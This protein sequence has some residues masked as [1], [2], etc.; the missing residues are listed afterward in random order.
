[1]RFTKWAENTWITDSYGRKKNISILNRSFEEI[2]MYIRKL[3]NA[4]MQ[5]LATFI[6]VDSNTTRNEFLI[7]ENSKDSQEVETYE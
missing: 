3:Q 7:N 5:T 6:H 4:T 1:V 2:Q